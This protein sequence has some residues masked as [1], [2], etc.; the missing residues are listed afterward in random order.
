MK[1]PRK[2]AI[3]KIQDSSH[4]NGGIPK[5]WNSKTI[6]TCLE[7]ANVMHMNGLSSSYL[8]CND[9]P[10]T[11][12]LDITQEAFTCAASANDLHGQARGFENKVRFLFLDSRQSIPICLFHF[13]S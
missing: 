1:S 6:A 9:I 7:S 3:Y 13:S 2:S 8:Q 12:Q 10:H 11:S 4:G 5:D